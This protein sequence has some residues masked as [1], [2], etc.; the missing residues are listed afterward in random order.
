MTAPGSRTEGTDQADPQRDLDLGLRAS[1]VVATSA[2]RARRPRRGGNALDLS[3]PRM[4]VAGLLE[5]CAVAIASGLA[6]AWRAGQQPN[7]WSDPPRGW[8]RDRS[9]GTIMIKLTSAL[10]ALSLCFTVACSGVNAGG[11]PATPQGGTL[12]ML[13][14]DSGFEPSTVKVKKG[15]P[16]K[17]VITRKTDKTCA[18]EIVI[19]EYGINTPLP[20]NTAVT[21]SFTPTQSGQLKYG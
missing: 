17:L 11:G 13:V 15:E 14:T 18:K 1:R 2:P 3:L 20:L 9:K 7:L 8:W 6:V 5:P 21:V 4:V 10:C 12:Q 19:D 16:V